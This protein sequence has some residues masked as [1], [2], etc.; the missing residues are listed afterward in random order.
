MRGAV[1]AGLGSARAPTDL[2]D[3]VTS[4]RQKTPLVLPECAEELRGGSEVQLKI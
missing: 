2:D 4:R 1:P 3:M